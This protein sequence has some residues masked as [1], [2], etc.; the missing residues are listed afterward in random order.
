MIGVVAL[1]A[2]RHYFGF[3]HNTLLIDWYIRF[4]KIFLKTTQQHIK[5]KIFQEKEQILIAINKALSNVWFKN[6]I[7]EIYFK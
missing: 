2:I 6:Y 7:K 5:I 3:T 4:D 1:N